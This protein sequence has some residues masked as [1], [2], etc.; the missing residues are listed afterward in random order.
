MIFRLLALS[1]SSSIHIMTKYFTLEFIFAVNSEHVFS[2]KIIKFY[3]EQIYFR[4]SVSSLHFFPVAISENSRKKET[5]ERKRTRHDQ[6]MI[7]LGTTQKFIWMAAYAK[8]WK[9][10]VCLSFRPLFLLISTEQFTYL[11]WLNWNG[12]WLGLDTRE[13]R[14]QRFP[15]LLFNHVTTREFN[16]RSRCSWRT[17]AD[18]FFFEKLSL[19]LPCTFY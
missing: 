13:A 4:I 9:A 16:T 3:C 2:L 8:R 15:C 6:R 1:L 14:C 12:W 11:A 10:K 7:K 17:N 19:P 5:K 18:N